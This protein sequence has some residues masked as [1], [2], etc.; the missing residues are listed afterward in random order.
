MSFLLKM[1]P[2]EMNLQTRC[3][4]C[5]QKA[6][7]LWQKLTLSRN[8]TRPCRRCG[9][10]LGVEQAGTGWF[11]FGW[12]P[13]ALAGL[14]PLPIKILLGIA[15]MGLI[16]FPH[17]YL[18][19][20]VNKSEQTGQ[21]TPPWLLPWLAVVAVGMFATDWINLLP[22]QGTKIVAF[23]VAVLLTI[24]VVATFRRMIP[25]SDEKMLAVVAG[26]ALLL[27]M[28]YFALSVL[29]ASLI[30]FLAGEQTVLEAR[31]EAKSHS[32]RLTRCSH[33]IDIVFA[34]ETE[35]HEICIAEDGWKLLKSDESVKV[36]TRNTDY[37]RLVMKV[38]P[39]D[40]SH[41]E[42]NTNGH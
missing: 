24:P 17:V 39:A 1:S 29:P 22:A 31:L 23:S 12:I 21:H 19:P 38:E 14:F 33:K 34:N 4:C 7:P 8:A 13:F 42:A 40:N 16:M 25:K 32:N 35:K 6:M 2:T 26:S 41:F 27:G 30:T 3:P 15:G 5:A 28:H 37:G 10:P 18:I 11:L 9:V 20:L 36:T